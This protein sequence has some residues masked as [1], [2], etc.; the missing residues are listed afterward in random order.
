MGCNTNQLNSYIT[1]RQFNPVEL[2]QKKSKCPK[3]FW[4]IVFEYLD[5]KDC[6]HVMMACK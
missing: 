6:A 4:F 5:I 1:T 3:N 2:V